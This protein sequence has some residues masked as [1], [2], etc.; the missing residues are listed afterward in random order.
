MPHELLDLLFQL[1]YQ[2]D[3]GDHK[4]HGWMD[5]LLDGSP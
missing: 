3:I 4:R 2:T 5:I 1:N